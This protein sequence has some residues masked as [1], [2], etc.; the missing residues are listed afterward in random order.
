M[1]AGTPGGYDFS[2]IFSILCLLSR[3]I[4]GEPAQPAGADHCCGFCRPAVSLSTLTSNCS[5]LLMR[6]YRAPRFHASAFN[7]IRAATLG[8]FCAALQHDKY[9]VTE[10]LASAYGTIFT[11]QGLDNCSSACLRS[12]FLIWAIVCTAA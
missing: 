3:I 9:T 1:S 2:Q 12:G 8:A 5:M 10:S 4:V 6:C 7:S 11:G